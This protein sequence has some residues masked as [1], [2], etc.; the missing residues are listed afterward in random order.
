MYLTIMSY[1]ATGE[2]H[3]LKIKT[4]ATKEQSLEGIDEYFLPAADTFLISDLMTILKNPE[5][6]D[7]EKA[8]FMNIQMNEY[9]PHAWKII[10]RWGFCELDLNY[11]VN[12]S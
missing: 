2:G 9:V 4:G 8:E 11:Y 12:L 1:M 6:P 10:K 7:Y 3:R 5:H